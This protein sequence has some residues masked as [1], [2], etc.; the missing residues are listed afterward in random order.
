MGCE[1]RAQRSAKAENT[2]FTEGLPR[3]Y[4]LLGFERLLNHEPA[5][6]KANT[7]LVEAKA[8]KGPTPLQRAGSRVWALVIE[9]EILW[10]SVSVTTLPR[11]CIVDA[12]L[13]FLW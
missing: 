1:H 11:G 8:E 12:M 13:S 9:P 7:P 5:K 6:P 3:S 10:F 4:K 2:G